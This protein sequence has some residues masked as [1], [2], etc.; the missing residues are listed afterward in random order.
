ML[1]YPSEIRGPERM[2]Q[3]DWE[4]TLRR[5]RGEFDEMPCMRVTPDAARTLFGLPPTAVEA[6]LQRL[7]A[8]G[9][10]SRTD[11]GEYIRRSA[12]P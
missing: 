1:R 7:E 2:A 9:F 10:L 8:E 11:G 4:A 3:P 12:R 6:L 5:V